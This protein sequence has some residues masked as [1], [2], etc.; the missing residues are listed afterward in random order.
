MRKEKGA[1]TCPT[2]EPKRISECP[3]NASAIGIAPTPRT[4]AFR[5]VMIIPVPKG[6]SGSGCSTY[7]I[8]LFVSA[9]GIISG[10]YAASHVG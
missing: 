9:S 10:A 5:V 8:G 1:G 2:D 7:D 4:A 6:L 3:E